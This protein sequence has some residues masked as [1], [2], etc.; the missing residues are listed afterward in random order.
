MFSSY[1]SQ[2]LRDER[3]WG[4]WTIWPDGRVWEPLVSA[5]HSGQ[6]FHFM[7]QISNGDIVVVD[8]Y[9]LNNNGF[10]AL[11]RLPP[12]APPGQPQFY[13]AFMTNTP[14]LD[15]TV[16]AGYHYPFTIPFQPRGMYGLTPF[17]HP[18]DEAAPV[19]TNGVRVGKFTQPSGAPDNDLLRCRFVSD[20]GQQ[21]CHQSVAARAHQK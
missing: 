19:G 11:F 16:G 6:A 5:F 15:Q 8:Y 7:T 21:H 9:N 17:T 3:M 13:S 20:S 14:P 2:G 4:I 10:G 12:S 1:E 18:Q